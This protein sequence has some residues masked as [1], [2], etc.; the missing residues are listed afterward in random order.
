MNQ[1][2]YNLDVHVSAQNAILELENEHENGHGVEPTQTPEYLELKAA[3]RQLKLSVFVMLVA[4]LAFTVGLWFTFGNYTESFQMNNRKMTS[5][6]EEMG[7]VR[8]ENTNVYIELKKT[9]SELESVQA[10]LENLNDK[11]AG[12]DSADIAQIKVDVELLSDKFAK[13]SLIGKAVG[14]DGQVMLA[15]PEDMV[16]VLII[17]ENQ[18][19]T[20][21]IMVAAINPTTQKITLVSVPRDLYVNG[22]R[23][24]AVYAQHGVEKLK[25][26]LQDILGL[27]IH[28]Y[29][30][31]NVNAFSDVVDMLGGID[32]Y[33]E[34]DIY[35]NQYPNGR[36]GY[37]VF[38]ISAGQ[39]HMDGKTA[40]K[41]ARSR[42]STSDF[43]RASRQQQVI[44]ALFRKIRELK[45][46]ENK[47]A[48]LQMY[49]TMTEH[50]HTDIDV[51]SALAYAKMFKNYEIE[52]NNVL[53]SSNY[54][55]SMI[56]AAGAYILLPSAGNYDQIKTYVFEL[57]VE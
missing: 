28:E 16:N 40:L 32:V 18:G 43:D 47:T 11:L 6:Y 54:L 52:R 4:F 10:A 23:I 9:Q 21:T 37:Q 42:K 46:S 17:G 7:E 29:A 25:Q 8:G 27:K 5:I 38:S 2:T 1:D 45:L 57:V 31:V 24:N 12:M 20:D 51:F 26:S 13:D 22:R 33:V 50:V 3:N 49:D 56:N 30:V 36:G 55:Y 48:A 14:S 44:E 35:D 39:H 41:Y 34:K 19:L 15:Y 53:T